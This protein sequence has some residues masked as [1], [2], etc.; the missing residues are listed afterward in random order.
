MTLAAMTRRACCVP[1]DNVSNVV[2]AVL[3]SSRR[4]AASPA[5]PLPSGAA[6]MEGCEQ[7]VLNANLALAPAI[8][9]EHA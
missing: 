5:F 7:I 6:H 9:Y 3:R 4:C 2:V 1:E 8:V